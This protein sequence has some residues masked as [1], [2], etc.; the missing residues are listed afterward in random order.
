[1]AERAC[2]LSRRQNAVLLGRLADAYV[3]TQELPLAVE[4]LEAALALKPEDGEAHRK[5]GQVLE[6]LGRPAEAARH[7]HEARQ[8]SAQPPDP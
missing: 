2:Q 7:F 4:A 3:E 8:L 6:S 1:L 5:L